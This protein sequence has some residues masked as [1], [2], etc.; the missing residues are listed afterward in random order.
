MIADCI[1]HWPCLTFAPPVVDP[2]CDPRLRLIFNASV[3]VF[4]PA[5][6]PA[7][8]WLVP[9]FKAD[10]TMIEPQR[11]FFP[12]GDQ[13]DKLYSRFL[14]I[15]NNLYPEMDL[16]TLGGYGMIESPP[17][18]PKKEKKSFIETKD[19]PQKKDKKEDK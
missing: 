6:G 4:L 13:G 1:V 16:A 12:E 2:V 7:F 14:T 15:F 17:K 9:Y 10:G 19:L 11:N 3:P 5:E 18:R 8:F